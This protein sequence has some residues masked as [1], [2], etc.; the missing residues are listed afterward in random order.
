MATGKLL[1][2]L[3]R[4]DL[5]VIDNPILHHLA[6]TTDHGFTHLLP[7]YVF[8]AH[9]IEVSGFLKDGEKSP[10]L[11][12]RSRVGG[13]WRCGPH[14]AKF[15]A[16]SVWDL[17]ESLEQLGSGL[18]IRV[19]D[20]KDVLSHLIHGL[21]GKAPGVGAV[22]M[23]EELSLEE[24]D[25]Q[26]AVASICSANDISFKL[27]PDEKYFVDDRDTGLETPK[28]LPDVFTSY[29]KSQEPLRERPRSVL[30]RVERSSLPLFLEKTSVPDQHHPFTVPTKLQDL[31]ARLIQPLGDIV[32]NAPP[33][34]DGAESAHPFQ[35]GE[36]HAQKRLRHLI[37]SGAMSS[38]KETRN[39]LLGLDFSTKLSAYLALGCVSARFVHEELL[40][41]EDGTDPEY[42]KAPG[43]GQ[44]ES[45]GT[46]AVRFELLWRDYMRLCMA[47]F[48]QKL[49]RQSG[50]TQGDKYDKTWK[51]ANKHE[52]K[53]DQDPS[54]DKIARILERFEEG[55]T[56]MGLIDASQ[57]ELFHTGYTSNRARQN[58]A[59]FL[60]KH[61]GIDW[62]YGAEWYEMLLVDFDV[63]SNWANWQYMA[64]VGNDPRGDAR[65][66]NP[67]KQ[68]FD[69]DKDG[70]YVR[71][72]VPELKDLEKPENVFQAW[73]ASSSD[74]E[75]HGLANNI[76]VTDPI[77]RIDFTVDRKP[78]GSRRSFPRRRGP[79]RGGRR[80]GNGQGPGGSGAPQDHSTDG[81]AMHH[82][83]HSNGLL[84]SQ[85]RG[86]GVPRPPR[87]G[88]YAPRAN[89]DSPPVYYNNGYP[90][91]WS[92][93]YNDARGRSN[94]GF[95]RGVAPMYGQ[96]MQVP[97]RNSYAQPMYFPPPTMGPGGA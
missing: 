12:A 95:Y 4:R 92:V 63:S 43:Y 26:D 54:P 56:G 28:D 22:W 84:Q 81:S 62:R 45:D 59:S 72:W 5:K 21:K 88:G 33:Y 51:T 78:K 68:A 32:R 41:L 13:Y 64:G 50:F 14:R 44:G 80:G 47:K 2:Y 86:R 83:A 30:P 76:M 66:F 69:Y 8:P 71:T 1:I 87:G 93:D 91:P 42:E 74:L 96:R 19:G 18:V 39:G 35:G 9:Q 3:L 77:K 73:T 36:S 60:S 52:A 55:T 46:A 6:T 65:I 97:F 48:G 49:F 20:V 25:E 16:Q 57:R 79:G 85:S 11:P 75:Q 61:L 94:Y 23:T 89:Y 10:Y 17:K 15:L 31:E 90:G 40:K 58:S 38:Y 70:T 29:R 82:S 24:K 67:V 34:P 27:W 7:I 37:K 53:H